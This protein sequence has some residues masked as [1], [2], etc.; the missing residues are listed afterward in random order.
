MQSADLACCARAQSSF[1]GGH[2]RCRDQP[3]DLRPTRAE[4]SYRLP[5]VLA[6]RVS[7]P[8][9]SRRRS[10][11]VEWRAGRGRYLLWR[12]SRSHGPTAS[13]PTTQGLLATSR[14]F[15]P[16]STIGRSRGAASWP[17]A[18][19]CGRDVDRGYVRA[20]SPSPAPTRFPR[21][22]ADARRAAVISTPDLG[23]SAV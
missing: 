9:R 4:A 19:P 10:G 22:V 21:S 15:M 13:N 16:L 17:R 18:G 11:S 8:P 6:F 2:P 1:R 7:L 12:I 14:R 20:S 5:E 3:R 23:V